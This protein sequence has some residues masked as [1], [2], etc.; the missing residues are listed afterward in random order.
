ML[1]SNSGS[2]ESIYTYSG[3]CGKRSDFEPV[4]NGY[5]LGSVTYMFDIGCTGPANPYVDVLGGGHSVKRD[6]CLAYPN[7]NIL[8]TPGCLGIQA[9]PDAQQFKD[10]MIL[11]QSG[12]A[13][14]I[15][16]AVSDG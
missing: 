5:C 16:L 14:T 3:S 6:H 4:D 10:C 8:G 9:K 12:G 11:V 13:K 1:T 15:P 2:A 7:G